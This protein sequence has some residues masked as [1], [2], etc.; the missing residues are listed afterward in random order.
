MLYE[1]KDFFAEILARSDA[2]KSLYAF[3]QQAWSQI[4]NSYDLILGWYMQVMCEHIEALHRGDIKDLIVGVPPRTS[5]STIC[6]IM[7]P[8]WA[9]IQSPHERFLCVSHLES[10]A[11]QHAGRHRDIVSSEWYNL[12]W[13]DRY[14]LR[15]DQNQKLNFSNTKG[16]Y[17]ISKAINSGATG[18]GSTVLIVDDANNAKESDSE[19]ENTNIVWSTSLSTRLN[20]PSKD[21]RLVTAQRTGPNDLI[22]HLLNGKGGKNWTYLMLPMEFEE[23]RRCETI[24]LP[25]TA[26]Y[27]WKDPRTKEGEVICPIRFEPVALERLK[28]GFKSDYLVATQLQLNPTI[29]DGGLFKKSWFQWWKADKPPKVDKV[30]ASFDTAF[31][32]AGEDEQR[33][34]RSYSV[35]TV[36]G[37]FR[38][39][40]G[41]SNLILLNMWRDRVEFPELRKAAQKIAKNYKYNGSDT[42]VVPGMYVPDVILI[43]SKAT[44]DPLRQELK[45]AGVSTVGFD[46]GPYGGKVR[47]A[48]LITHIVEAGR[49]WVPAIGP[50][51]T[52]LSDYSKKFVDACAAFPQDADSKDIVDTFS[53][54][55]LKEIKNH[56]IVHPSDPVE[57]KVRRKKDPR[58]DNIYGVDKNN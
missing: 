30:I 31:K 46:P 50:N 10:L 7:Y 32:K 43:E 26:P 55:L 6:S 44:G 24:I 45:R 29:P 33:F 35:C 57:K 48:S 52:R 56:E 1:E 28:E 40:F 27:K 13:G 53:Q 38:D 22:D 4:E 3:T 49:I 23:K 54:V 34:K 47:R 5:K 51:Y 36:W 20:N 25:S 37:L 12:R 21:K 15:R 39:E 14:I 58:E 19:R 18:L 2:E 11:T 42:E 9:W 41:I 8:S 16:G 17:R